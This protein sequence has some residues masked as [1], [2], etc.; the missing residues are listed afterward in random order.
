MVTSKENKDKLLN[1]L[2]ENY[3]ELQLNDAGKEALNSLKEMDFPT[4]RTEDWKYTRVGKII[5]KDFQLS[6]D[7]L[8]FNISDYKI[9]GLSADLLV[10]VNGVFQKN[11]SEITNTNV[12]ITPLSQIEQRDKEIISLNFGKNSRHQDEIFT[13]IN[14]AF[15]TDG[16]FIHISENAKAEQ[17]IH[18]INLS[19][20]KNVINQPRNLIVAEKGSEI[21]VIETYDSLDSDTVFNNIVTEIVVKE[22]AK[23][24]YDQLQKEKQ[25]TFLLSTVE[26]YQERDSTFNTN[27]V[28]LS[29]DWVRNNLNIVV[30]GENCLTNL[31]GVYLLKGD[32]HVDNHTMV[33]HKKPNCNSNELYR[34][35]IDGNATAV[36]NGKVY[37]REDAQQINAF[38]YN[39]NV[40]LTDE[41]T[42]NS[43]PELEIYAD[44]VK[45]SHGSTTGQ[46]DEEALFYLR[47]RGLSEE[48]ARKM[49]IGAFAAD[50]FEKIENEALLST[51]KKT[52]KQEFDWDTD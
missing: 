28:T 42:V 37:V 19:G 30:D 12:R 18:I 44:D 6:K 15:P 22:N 11:L 33:D 8:S 39:G 13:A 25:G 20:G 47:A 51:I 16:A 41:A 35:V 23:V 10:F 27:T 4:S 46:L 1:S 2:S 34:G 9:E 5:K 32:Q 7:Q 38:Q 45:C 52:L 40:L 36:F 14:T 31:S 17:P 3:S 26:V 21:G 24:S 50:A 43:K 29:G 48:S 49:L